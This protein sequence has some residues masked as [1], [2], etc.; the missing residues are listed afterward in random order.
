MKGIVVWWPGLKADI[1][2][3]WHACDGL[4][5][6]PDYTDRVLVGAG[7]DYAQQTNIGSKTQYHNF[8]G[9]THNH[10]IGSGEGIQAGS[11]KAEYTDD[12]VVT[13]VTDNADLLPR[14][15][16]GWWIIKM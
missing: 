12:E 3:G 15:R 6:T 10:P 8:S 14:A 1:P 5:G 4:A 16:A 9:D 2:A 13:G 11:G 7:G